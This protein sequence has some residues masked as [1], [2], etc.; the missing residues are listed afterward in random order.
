MAQPILPKL[1]FVGAGNISQ[2][3]IKGILKSRPNATQQILATAPSNKNLEIIKNLGCRTSLL[4]DIRSE[5]K[6]FNPEFV[7][8][9][10]KPQVFLKETRNHTSHLH[11]LL[12]DVRKKMK[13]S[14]MA[15]VPSSE[16]ENAVRVMLNNAAEIGAT[17]VF[18]LRPDTYKHL[19]KTERDDFD[20]Q[21]ARAKEVLKLLG[22]PVVEVGDDHLLDVSTGFCGSGIALF[23]EMIQ[24]MSDAAVQEGLSRNE[25]IQVSAQMAKAAGDMILKNKK[26]PYVLRDEVCS[27][28]GTTIQG[29]S[30]WHENAISVKIISAVKASIARAK[31]LFDEGVKR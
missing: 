21:F 9:C 29:V 18:Y 8:L 28:A 16:S 24:A 22:E 10:V 12:S 4:E 19:S 13:L 27:P 2:S 1:L 30:K 26:H 3:I 7:F 14:V 31:T 17:S 11:G 20:T 25:A 15:G 5:V 23:Y 6:Q